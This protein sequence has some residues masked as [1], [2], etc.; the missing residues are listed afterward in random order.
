VPPAVRSGPLGLLGASGSSVR[1]AAGGL[2][3]SDL[4]GGPRGLDE[5]R[6]LGSVTGLLAPTWPSLGPAAGKPLVLARIDRPG[7]PLALWVVDADGHPHDLGVELPTGVA[8]DAPVVAARWDLEH[9]RLLLAAPTSTT[10]PSSGLVVPLDYW[11][12]QLTDRPSI[13]EQGGAS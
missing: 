11:L 3:L 5:D 12:V 2:F 13:G 8:P 4:G 9:G 10:A 1:R 6:Q 7:K